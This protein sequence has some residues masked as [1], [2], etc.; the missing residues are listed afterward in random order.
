M[1][2]H[3]VF[4]DAT[5]HSTKR[6]VIQARIPSLEELLVLAA[7][8]YRN[9]MDIRTRCIL[10]HEPFRHV[11]DAPKYFGRIVSLQSLSP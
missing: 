9:I 2:G 5:H 8:Y 3:T 10:G 7:T 4:P 1:R 6:M 11:L